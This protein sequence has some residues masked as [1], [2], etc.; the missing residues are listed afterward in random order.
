MF[1]QTN[2][3]DC[4]K[5]CGKTLLSPFA[6]YYCVTFMDTQGQMSIILIAQKPE[7]YCCLEAIFCF[8]EFTFEVLGVMVPQMLLKGESLDHLSIQHSFKVNFLLQSTLVRLQPASYQPL[9]LT[10]FKSPSPAP[11]NEVSRQ[12]SEWQ[13]EALR[14]VRTLFCSI[15]PPPSSLSCSVHPEGALDDG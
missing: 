2:Y 3:P 10:C 9:C 14:G 13:D 8:C 7:T 12:K 1:V 15:H 11:H 4:G 6:V 5:I